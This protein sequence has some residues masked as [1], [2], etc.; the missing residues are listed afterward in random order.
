MGRPIIKMYAG[1]K[2]WAKE[3]YRRP[4]AWVN[5]VLYSVIP[6]CPLII[7]NRTSDPNV[8]ALCDSYT[9][10]SFW[11]LVQYAQ[12][13]CLIISATSLF[14]GNIF[15][16]FFYLFLGLYGAIQWDLPLYSICFTTEMH[17]CFRSASTF[18]T[19]NSHRLFWWMCARL[20][21]FKVI[22]AS[23][24]LK[25]YSAMVT[26]TQQTPGRYLSSTTS[27]QTHTYR[28]NI[29]V[30]AFS[31]GNCTRM[32][33][34]TVKRPCRWKTVQMC[35]VLILLELSTAFHTTNVQVLLS[36]PFDLE[37]SCITLSWLK[38]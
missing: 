32:T 29:H 17:L 37:V 16:H 20:N 33:L 9:S 2:R 35:F 25:L 10:G 18:W 12:H 23:L 13:V 1:H 34:L 27:R 28:V 6:T 8:R 3:S 11:Y 21:M 19:L 14:S 24:M 5:Y 31:R 38:S 26:A 22:T 7:K 4:G 36:S 30:S 15:W